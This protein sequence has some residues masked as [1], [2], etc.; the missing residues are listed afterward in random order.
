[1][2]NIPLRFPMMFQPS[3]APVFDARMPSLGILGKKTSRRF[4]GGNQL[5]VLGCPAGSDRN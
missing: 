5:Q 3:S 1:M 2:G 4:H